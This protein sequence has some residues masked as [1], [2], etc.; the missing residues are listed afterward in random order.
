MRWDEQM[1]HLRGVMSPGRVVPLPEISNYL[2]ADDREQARAQLDERA[3]G[4]ESQHSVFRVQWPDGQ[5][6]WIT[7]HSVPAHDERGQPDGR[8]GVNWDSTAMQASA[9]AV[10]EREVA[11]AE[12]RAKSQAMSRISHELRTP[13]NAVLGFAQLIRGAGEEIDAERLARWL[14]H[15]EDAGRHLLALIDDV[16]ALSGAEVGELKLVREAVAFASVVDAALPLVAGQAQEQRVNLLRETIAGVVLAD[17]VRLRQVLINLLSN[18]IKSN[19][20]GGSVRLWTR[21]QGGMVALHVADTGIGIA[22]ERL[23]HAF[24]P[25]NRLGAEA[26][27]VEGSGIGLALVKALVEAMQGQVEVRSELGQGTEFIVRLPAA[28]AQ[29]AT[30]LPAAATLDAGAAATPPQAGARVLYIEDNPVNA[31][32]VQEMLAHRPAITLEVAEDGRS[33]VQSALETLP[34]LILIDMQLPDIDGHA[35]LEALRADPRTAGLY[36][37]ALSANATPA[38]LD[39]ARIAGFAD[40]WTKPIEFRSF[41]ERMDDVLESIADRGR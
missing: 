21:Q 24:E 15:I 20:P 19:R 35:V 6:R 28:P 3:F 32:L 1:F 41:L 39:A 7:S 5:V 31:L 25:F 10:R 26:S 40:Y 36:C 38:D 4:G 29:G 27:G 13:L 30:V 9:D 17:P 34:D 33:G 2:H 12:S 37:V 14:A 16:L 18:A 22:P 11:V 23:S 8:I